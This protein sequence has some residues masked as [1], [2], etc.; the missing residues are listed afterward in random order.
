MGSHYL[1]EKIL[2]IPFLNHPPLCIPFLGIPRIAVHAPIYETEAM[3]HLL[4][5]I[6][7]CTYL[8]RKNRTI[9][10]V[11]ARHCRDPKFS[12]Q[13]DTTGGIR[14]RLKIPRETNSLGFRTQKFPPPFLEKK[15]PLS[16]KRAHHAYAWYMSFYILFE[17]TQISIVANFKRTSK[18]RTR[19]CVLKISQI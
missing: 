4:K 8:I 7:K 9:S 1:I 12:H 3:V 17:Q 6:P 16:S 18:F 14:Y 10:Y 11:S 19:F 5:V 2:A 15:F 13:F